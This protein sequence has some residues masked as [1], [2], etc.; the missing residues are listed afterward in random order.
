MNSKERILAVLRHE[1]PDLIPF[2]MYVE[3]LNVAGLAL[4]EPW[5]KLLD[6]GLSLHG[7]LAVQAHKVICP[8]TNMD[9][10]HHY[11]KV[12]SWS[13]VDILM[14][15]NTPHEVTGKIS[16]PA[17]NLSLKAKL[18]SLDMSEMLP[19]FP[20]DGYI[21]KGVE[22]Y[23]A[24]NYLIENAEYTPHY[25]DIKEFQMVLGDY[26]IV[27]AFV[28]KSP[29]QSMI[30]LM[31]AK[32]LSL[33]FYM[34]QKEFDE[35]YRN[36]YKKELEIYKIAAE[37]PADAIW[38]PDN[39]TSLVTNPRFFEKYSL[40]FY[41]EVSEILHKHDKK[42]IVHMDGTLKSIGE[43][44]AKTKI[45]VI[46]SFTAPPVGDF[47]INEARKI[48]KD[49]VIWANFPESVS[50]QGQSAVRKKTR[51]MLTN[52][53]PGDNFLMGISE[54]FPSAMHLFA[55]VPTILKTIQKYGKYPISHA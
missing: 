19:W 15:M 28:P 36:I 52:A 16:T 53:A 14:A 46:E 38:G 8:S 33:N 29:F 1:E 24:L 22:D 34:H 13:P 10:I 4:Y 41:N 7:A 35:L 26:G 32:T 42:Y 25:N 51:E 45:D 31:G 30:M 54:G 9:I 47:P 43:L 6:N 3:T 48:W 11:E 5:R 17:G 40:P 44:I 12:T 39:V 23:S 37:S 50:L 49:K 18:K 20:E 21:I 2:T 55:S 27:S